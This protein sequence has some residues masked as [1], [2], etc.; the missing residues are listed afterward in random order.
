MSATAGA[1]HDPGNLVA[2]AVEGLPECGSIPHGGSLHPRLAGPAG[3]SFPHP[4]K[5]FAA[6]GRPLLGSWFAPGDRSLR[7][8]FLHII[9][10][11][12]VWT[13][14]IAARPIRHLPDG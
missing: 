12:E 8:T 3:G 13:D 5:P 4:G 7:E 14:R 2:T 11:M 10:N 9:V 1:N 6:R